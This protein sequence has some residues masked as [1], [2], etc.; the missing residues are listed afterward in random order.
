[1]CKNSV[2]ELDMKTKSR[3]EVCKFGHSIITSCFKGLFNAISI[4]S[5]DF[6]EK[7]GY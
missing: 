2:K 6:Q 7:Y 4:I 1:M 5:K 3:F